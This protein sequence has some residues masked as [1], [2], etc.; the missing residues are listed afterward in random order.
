MET[1]EKDLKTKEAIAAELK[2]SYDFII[3]T[4]K[5]TKDD[6]LATKIT[7]PWGEYSSMSAMLIVLG[8]SNEHLGQ[9]IAYSRMNEITPP[10]SKK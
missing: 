1:L 2:K 6:A 5:N 4:I 7:F 10:W 3:G 9:L 8:H